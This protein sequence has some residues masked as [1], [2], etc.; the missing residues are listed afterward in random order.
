M[1]DDFSKL[2]L[3]RVLPNL[4]STAVMRCFMETVVG[5]YG[6][7]SQVRVDQGNEFAGNFS[8]WMQQ[9]GVRVV[10]TAP[11]APWTNGIAERM[12]RFVKGLLKKALTGV[13]REEWADHVPLV[14]ATI[15]QSTSRA[16]GFSPHEIFFA[17]APVPLAFGELGA[18]PVVDAKLGEKDQV[19]AICEY[20]QHAKEVMARV[21]AQAAANHASYHEK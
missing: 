3:L 1:V 18:L 6:R 14:Q 12:V 15:N 19:G 9:L 20:I 11:L 2:T 17:E 4:D 7:P 10:V 8:K 21:R 16:T 5:V 13:P